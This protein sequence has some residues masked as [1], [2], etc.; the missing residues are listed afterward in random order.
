MIVDDITNCLIQQTIDD[1]GKVYVFNQTERFE[2]VS[3]NNGEI[4]IASG[5]YEF[6]VNDK[7]SFI[8]LPKYKTPYVCDV[9]ADTDGD[10][11][12]DQFDLDADGDG[13]IDP[14]APLA[15]SKVGIEL[16]SEPALVTI[17]DV[18][19]EPIIPVR[20][21]AF[22]RGVPIT[23]DRYYPLYLTISEAQDASPVGEYH[24][25]YLDNWTYYMPVGVDSWHGNYHTCVPDEPTIIDADSYNTYDWQYVDRSYERG[26]FASLIPR[27]YRLQLLGLDTDENGTYETDRNYSLIK[28]YNSD[29]A[30]DLAGNVVTPGEYKY[31]YYQQE[32]EQAWVFE[33][34]EKKTSEEILDQNHSFFQQNYAYQVEAVGKF[35]VGTEDNAKHTASIFKYFAQTTN[36]EQARFDSVGGVSYFIKDN[37]AWHFNTVLEARLDNRVIMSSGNLNVGDKIYFVVKPPPLAPQ[38]VEAERLV[39]PAMP[40]IIEVIAPPKAPSFL[41]S[42]LMPVPFKPSDVEAS[43]DIFGIAQQSVV[44]TLAEYS[45]IDVDVTFTAY[46]T[47]GEPVNI[48][49]DDPSIDATLTY[50]GNNQWKLNSAVAK[51]VQLNATVSGNEIYAKHKES[52]SIEIIEGAEVP[53]RVS[54]IIITAPNFAPSN[55]D[56]EKLVPPNV[57]TPLGLDT[58]PLE[59]RDIGHAYSPYMPMV[60]SAF[61][62][63]SSPVQITAYR[64]DSRPAGWFGGEPSNITMEIVF[65]P[66]EVNDVTAYRYDSRP[67]GW[68]GG[69]PTKVGAISLTSFGLEDYIGAG[70]L[71][72]LSYRHNRVPLPDEVGLEN[73]LN[74]PD[75]KIVQGN[76]LK[77][78]IYDISLFH[79][80][81][82]YDDQIVPRNPPSYDP[83]LYLDD[84]FDA[85][86]SII[87]WYVSPKN[88][89]EGTSSYESLI[90][91][92]GINPG[93]IPKEGDNALIQV[94]DSDGNVVPDF[95]QSWRIYQQILFAEKLSST[96][97]SYRYLGPAPIVEPYQSIDYIIGYAASGSLYGQYGEQNRR[98]AWQAHHLAIRGNYKPAKYSSTVPFS[99]ANSDDQLKGYT[100]NY[101]EGDYIYSNRAHSDFKFDSS[102]LSVP[103]AQYVIST[104]V[105]GSTGESCTTR[106]ITVKGAAES[107]STE[108]ITVKDTDIIQFRQKATLVCKHLPDIKFDRSHPSRFNRSEYDIIP[109]EI[110]TF[111]GIDQNDQLTDAWIMYNWNKNSDIGIREL[112]TEYQHLQQKVKAAFVIYK[113]RK[114]IFGTNHPAV[115]QGIR[116]P[117]TRYI[118]D[119]PFLY[120]DVPDFVRRQTKYLRYYGYINLVS[121]SL[122]SWDSDGENYLVDVNARV[123]RNESTF[124]GW[125]IEDNGF[126]KEINQDWKH[127]YPPH[128]VIRVRDIRSKELKNSLLQD[129][130]LD[131]IVVFNKYFDENYNSSNNLLKLKRTNTT[132]QYT[133]PYTDQSGNYFPPQKIE[134]KLITTPLCLTLK[135]GSKVA[136]MEKTTT[137]KLEK[138]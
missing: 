42:Y 90:N 21:K 74:N 137:D 75:Q 86:D 35:D 132:T 29:D 77:N 121:P 45:A 67:A 63:P 94:A 135:A 133:K 93:D 95:T 98:I 14:R 114:D 81:N 82:K 30:L 122:N 26:I 34:T 64:Y 70:D 11:I 69:D 46:S 24:E 68:F 76:V 40:N 110:T 103:T 84:V 104:C 112:N 124:Y 48:V 138:K 80:S 62:D 118:E 52:K 8:Y 126:V 53:N 125:D 56:A 31:N 32:P 71:A 49:F 107:S 87:G 5:Q 60:I 18:N 109:K 108:P 22:E 2:V 59:P 120:A 10:G 113:V 3:A 115:P 33:V 127:A 17:T 44:W 6:N 61:R 100:L 89:K 78:S 134:F 99:F 19:R 83:Q 37:G 43:L 123:Q 36:G 47:S 130:S 54:V 39:G 65:S 50:L 58:I 88:L 131:D 38:L 1:G 51:V 105:T 119:G 16:V 66:A 101:F 28:T 97:H 20:V 111:T 72:S 13:V 12:I 106:K 117:R 41:E 91:D 9:Y 85:D 57:V 27:D 23:V 116:K 4:T 73:N 102:N 15:P 79:F 129:F 25:H 92:F 128:S 55:V 7:L 96:Y 136:V